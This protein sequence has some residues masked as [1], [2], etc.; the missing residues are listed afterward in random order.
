MG[1]LGIFQGKVELV[2][3]QLLGALAELLALRKAQ[4]I[5]QPPIGLLGLCQ[6]CLD[7]GE[8]GLQ[9]GIQLICQLCNALRTLLR[10]SELPDSDFA[11][12]RTAISVIPGQFGHG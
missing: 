8:A 10:I 2:R 9:Q 12:S 1:E 7:L 11:K 6:R 5:L 3:R 4:D